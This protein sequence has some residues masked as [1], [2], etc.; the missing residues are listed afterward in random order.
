MRVKWDQYETALLIETFWKIEDNHENKNELISDLSLR[1]RN[2][3]IKKGLEIDDVYRNVNGI[4]MQLSPIAHAFFPNRPTLTTSSMFEK[5]VQLYKDDRKEFDN[6]LSTAHVMAGDEMNDRKMPSN[7]FITWIHNKE[8]KKYSAEEIIEK[9]DSISGFCVRHN[10]IDKT[11]W[12]QDDAKGFITSMYKMLADRSFNIVYKEDKAIVQRAIAL[13]KMYL[14]D[15]TVDTERTILTEKSEVV[16]VEVDKHAIAEQEEIKQVL[17]SH[18]PYGFNYLSPIEL[19]K[20]RKNFFSDM[21]EECIDDVVEL[22]NLIKNAGVEYSGKIYVISKDAISRINKVINQQ[23][24]LGETI[25]YYEML[26]LANEDW[27][28]EEHIISE[29]MLKE[30]LMIEDTK[31]QYKAGYFVTR[32][33]RCTEK[34]A[35]CR[36]INYVWAE[37]TLRTFEELSQ[38]LPF[39]PLNKIKYALSVGENFVWNSFETYTRTENFIISDSQLEEIEN[40]AATLCDE[41]GSASFEEIISDDIVAENYELSETALNDLVFYRIK[42]RF[43]KNGKAVTRAGEKND[44][45]SEIVKYCRS[46]DICTIEELNQLMIDLTGTIRYPVVVEAANSAMVRVDRDSFV[47]DRKVS[48][49]IEK[50][51]TVLDKMI[52]GNVMGMKE[53]SSFA[54]LP[55]CG[56]P[57][58]L[59]LLESYC[60]RFSRLFYYACVTPNSKNAGA[61]VRKKCEVSYHE[62]M[63]EAVARSNVNL[64]EK[65]IFDYLISSGLM[66]KKSYNN[67][68]DLIV[69]SGEIREGRL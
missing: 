66:L 19:M 8:I 3:A 2:M 59:F 67:M 18:F 13:Y 45:S 25:F 41:K 29:E 34:E 44:I 42:D 56:F 54:T 10:I 24:E 65:D 1:L 6:I 11:I 49:D 50:I 55:Y 31:Y 30:I 28:F 16:D 9:L 35:L 39:V 15:N 26:F 7:E 23:I 32:E 68:N 5:M 22:T 62:L 64:N 27:L 17:E 43:S 47:E 69:K 60:R 33:S 52:I 38:L 40:K 36:D 4:T 46:K 20:F 48:F 14:E 61:I 12:E 57:W 58:N 21:G 51:D 53:F 37:A 63:A